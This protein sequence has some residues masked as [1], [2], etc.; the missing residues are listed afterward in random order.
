[1]AKWILFSLLWWITGN[2]I[3]AVLLLLVIVYL[4][5]RRFIGLS[6]NVF[7][8]FQLSRKAS[9]LKQTLQSNPHDTSAKLELARILNEKKKY[10]EAKTYLEQIVDIRRDSADVHYELGL[11]CLK[12]GQLEQGTASMNEALRLNP[13]VK[14][15]EPYLRLG[16]AYAAGQPERAVSYLEQFRELHSSSCEAYYRL[17]RLYRRLGRADKAKA[18]FQ[19]ALQIYKALP[20]YSRRAQRRW[21]LLAWLYG[22]A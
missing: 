2:P 20:R 19:E 17:G 21:A 11:C 13:R 6:P 16:E 14:Y 9:R 22:F 8:P 1:M 15:G 5:D 10:A 7:K 18:A 12:L 3:V 4:L